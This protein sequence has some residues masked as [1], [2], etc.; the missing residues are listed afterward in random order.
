MCTADD[1]PA[2]HRSKLQQIGQ[3]ADY[4]NGNWVTYILRHGDHSAEA[5]ATKSS[6]LQRFHLLEHSLSSLIRR[7]GHRERVG[8]CKAMSSPPK[9]VPNRTST[10]SEASCAVSTS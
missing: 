3:R 6:G 7:H 1:L 10:S 2:L 8:P 9:S 4:R 5:G